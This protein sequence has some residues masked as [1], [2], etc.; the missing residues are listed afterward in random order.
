MESS[1]LELLSFSVLAVGCALSIIAS[2]ITV[3]WKL[4]TRLQE[5]GTRIESL[6]VEL[7]RSESVI[8]R[9]I[10]RQENLENKIAEHH[11]RL[12]STNQDLQNLHNFIKRGDPRNNNPTP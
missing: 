6:T 5:L 10:S 11:V 1:I 8:H 9:I 12:E 4:G 2:A 3:A 7:R